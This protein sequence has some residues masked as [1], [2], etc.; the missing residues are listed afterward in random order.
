[1]MSDVPYAHLDNMHKIFIFLILREG[2]EDT[3]MVMFIYLY[4]YIL[5]T[6][7]CNTIFLAIAQFGCNNVESP[8]PI[9]HC[10]GTRHYK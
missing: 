3:E 9:D 4:T 7:T 5:Y 1:M 10:S 2:M 8:V 6:H